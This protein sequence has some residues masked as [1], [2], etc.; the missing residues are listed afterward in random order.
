MTDQEISDLAI[1]QEQDTFDESSI[2]EETYDGEDGDYTEHYD[3]IEISA[4]AS[5][6]LNSAVKAQSIS[7]AVSESTSGRKLCKSLLIVYIV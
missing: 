5:Q 6:Q 4:A 7:A 2:I 3:P 1:E